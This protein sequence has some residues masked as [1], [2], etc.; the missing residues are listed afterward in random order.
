ME[1]TAARASAVRGQ[2]AQ[3]EAGGGVHWGVGGG[4]PETPSPPALEGPEPK[5]RR[6]LI[7]V[8]HPLLKRSEN[9]LANSSH[10]TLQSTILKDISKKGEKKLLFAICTVPFFPG[11]NSD[12]KGEI[13]TIRQ[14]ICHVQV[15]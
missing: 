3:G 8:L 9:K 4:D 2:P 7:T 11:L 5:E 15:M 14:D 13:K 12:F 10:S 1:V 6:M